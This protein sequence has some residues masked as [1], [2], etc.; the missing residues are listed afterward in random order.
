MDYNE[1]NNFF[2]SQ[3]EQEKIEFQHKNDVWYGLKEL[4]K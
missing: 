4:N 1:L 3:I 2:V